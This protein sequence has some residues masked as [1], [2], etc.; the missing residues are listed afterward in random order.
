MLV[1]NYNLLLMVASTWS[2]ID[3]EVEVEIKGGGRRKMNKFI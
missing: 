2:K 3:R 1:T